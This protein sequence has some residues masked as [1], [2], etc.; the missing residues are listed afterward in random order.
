M[1]GG[2]PM[3]RMTQER[4]AERDRCIMQILEAVRD[5]H[6]KRLVRFSDI[7]VSQDEGGPR[8]DTSKRTVDLEFYPNHTKNDY[9]LEVTLVVLDTDR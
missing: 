5:L 8:G 2:Y 1:A 3:A 7:M 6:E 9:R 4:K